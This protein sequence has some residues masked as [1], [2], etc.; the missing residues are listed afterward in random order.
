MFRVKAIATWDTSTVWGM[1]T[2]PKRNKKFNKMYKT[3][4]QELYNIRYENEHDMNS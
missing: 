4:E 2:L 3:F 1:I